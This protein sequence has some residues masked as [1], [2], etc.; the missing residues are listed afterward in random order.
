MRWTSLISI[1]DVFFFHFR[2]STNLT[3]A[4][5]LHPLQTSGMLRASIVLPSHP[6]DP[7]SPRNLLSKNQDGIPFSDTFN[8][9]TVTLSTPTLRICDALNS[10]HTPSHQKLKR[11]QIDS[12]DSLWRHGFCK[13]AFTNETRVQVWDEYAGS[14]GLRSMTS[15]GASGRILPRFYVRKRKRKGS[16]YGTATRSIQRFFDVLSKEYSL[17][18]WKY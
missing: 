16:D 9:H 18:K 12:E 14:R 15:F 10:P 13:F 5:L 8:L 2:P 11:F 7:P 1:G 6:T 17:T 3:S 4:L